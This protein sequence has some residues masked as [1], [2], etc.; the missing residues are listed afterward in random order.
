MKLTAITL[1]AAALLLTACTTSG[2][3][4]NPTTTPAGIPIATSTAPT[5]TKPTID[6][7]APGF[8]IDLK[9][10]NKQCFGSA[11]CNITVEPH[12]VYAGDIN[13]MQGG[14]CRFTYD[15]TGGSD[16]TVTQTLT[17]HG[18]QFNSP[19]A[20]VSTPKSSTTLKAT[21]TDVTC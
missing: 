6:P 8:T 16:G 3:L 17:L 7:T 21:I 20:F 12:L 11:G 1:T 2:N 14:S 4:T 10:T 5:P 19:P 9:V 15:I 18:T 13:V